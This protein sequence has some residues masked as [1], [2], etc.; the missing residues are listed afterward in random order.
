MGGRSNKRISFGAF[1]PNPEITLKPLQK[2]LGF[3]LS[4]I[5][6]FSPWKKDWKRD[7]DPF[8]SRS[9]R[10]II[11]NK[12]TPFIKWEPATWTNVPNR[13]INDFPLDKIA[14]GLFD[15]YIEKWAVEAKKIKKEI[16][17]SFGH[18][19]N[20][21]WYHWAKKR[22]QYKKTFLHIYNVFKRLNVSNV[23]WVFCVNNYP[24]DYMS[25]FPQV[26]RKDKKIII[27]LDGYNAEGVWGLRWKPFKQIFD[28][29][30]KYVSRNF[31]DHQLIIA[32]MGCG[33]IGGDKQLWI[34]DAFISLKKK[35]N[36]ISALIWFNIN[37]EADWRIGNFRIPL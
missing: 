2:K 4:I 14:E 32:E 3:P 35:F 30:Y 13:M 12:S 16:W 6:I 11:K 19:M 24:L 20:G 29:P 10:L 27:G 17:L 15:K 1:T 34:N 33:E 31:M 25:Y 22:E 18:E 37:K 21:Q 8:P 26:L 28:K 23:R 5:L 7:M 9:C 36:K